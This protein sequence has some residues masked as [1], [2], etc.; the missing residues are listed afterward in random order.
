MQNAPDIFVAV[1]VTLGQ[2]SKMARIALRMCQVDAAG[3]A[4]VTQHDISLLER[5]LY[6]YPAPKERIL[7][8]LGCE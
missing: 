4:Y 7:A 1:G 8:V 2:K 3:L 5:D 6:V